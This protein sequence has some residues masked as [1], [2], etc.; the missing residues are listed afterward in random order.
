MELFKPAYL[1]YMELI[2]YDC[3]DWKPDPNPVI[4]PEFSSVYLQ[5]LPSKAGKNKILRYIDLVIQ[6]LIK[7][8]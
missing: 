2:G 3:D 4:D 8:G 6:K 7:R 5:N 1:P